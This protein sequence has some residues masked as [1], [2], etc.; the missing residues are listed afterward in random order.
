MVQ[1]R[2]LL[3][4]FSGEKA[5]ARGRRALG[6]GAL[7]AACYTGGVVATAAAPFEAEGGEYFR[8]DISTSLNPGDMSQ[9]T[10]QTILGE[11][12]ASFDGPIVAPGIRVTPMLQEDAYMRFRDDSFDVTKVRLTEAEISEA[13]NDARDGLALRF[14]IGAF[15][16]AGAASIV[17][18]LIKKELTRTQLVSAAS[19]IAIASLGTVGQGASTYSP[20]QFVALKYSSVI[21]QALKSKDTFGKITNHSKDISGY[22]ASTVAVSDALR[23]KYSPEQSTPVQKFMLISDAHGANLYP[24]VAK[25]AKEQGINYVLD[26]GDIINFGSRAELVQSGMLDGIEL[27]GEQG[28]TYV[29]VRGNHDANTSGGSEVLEALGELENVVLLQ[30]GD[31][32]YNL[33]SAGGVKIAG[34]NDTRYFGD[35]GHADRDMLDASIAEYRAALKGQTVDLTLAHQPN[36]VE[37]FDTT[38]VNGHMHRPDLDENHIQVG[39]LSA[40]GI[41]NQFPLSDEPTDPVLS[42]F[43]IVTFDNT[44]SLSSLDRYSYPP[45]VSPTSDGSYTVT[46]I[47]G[48]TI[49]KPVVDRQCTDESEPLITTLY[50]SE[51]AAARAERGSR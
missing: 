22:I 46:R 50:T 47:A 21:D 27:L 11:V 20:D 5:K 15:A 1:A 30:P 23:T 4:K 31:D 13:L 14:M 44:C 42:A 41:L 9:V 25:V 10:A 19:A 12:V 3:S 39:S 34:F 2:E 33:V 38:T 6:I 7:A 17:D 43:D 28:I 18:R 29:F 8:A 48:A 51:L 37:K 24:L 36:Q 45:F 49:A 35:D 16:V 32:T 40:G 26:A